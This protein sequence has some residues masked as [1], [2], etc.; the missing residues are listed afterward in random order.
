MLTLSTA[1]RIPEDLDDDGQC[2][3]FWDAAAQNE[4]ESFHRC[5]FTQEV[6]MHHDYEEAYLFPFL[7]R[8]MPEF[9]KADKH[10]PAT[11]ELLRQH[12]VIHH[13]LGI[14]AEYLQACRRGTI[15]FQFSM[16]REKL[17]SFGT[18]LWTHLDQEVKTLGAENMKRYWKLEE[19]DSFPM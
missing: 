4:P 11:A 18:V 3:Q 14:V 15:D 8:R 13:G 6:T 1:S 19:L 16:L 9:R 7:A 5:R 17:D 2:L 12:E 10:N